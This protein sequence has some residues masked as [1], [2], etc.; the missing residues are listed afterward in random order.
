LFVGVGVCLFIVAASATAA[1]TSTS[2]L[3]AKIDEAKKY[4]AKSSW[5][6]ATQALHEALLM[7]RQKTPLFVSQ[8]VVVKGDAHGLGVYDALPGGTVEG[9]HL[10]LYVEVENASHE[11]AGD[12]QQRTTLE[13]TGAFQFNENDGTTEALGERALGIQMV[14]SHRSESVS[15]LGVDVVLGEKAPA[16]RYGVDVKVVDKHSG[17][18]AHRF[19]AFVLR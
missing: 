11:D 14:V 4:A 13:V 17:Q 8:V 19:V 16:G 18:Q 5:A 6:E 1:G 15:F 7:A 2:P 10:H 3:L 12:G 9:R